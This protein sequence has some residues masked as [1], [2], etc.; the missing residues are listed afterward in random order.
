M[1]EEQQIHWNKHEC[2][3]VNNGETLLI[4]LNGQDDFTQMIFI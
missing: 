1:C 3:E 2:F 4:S